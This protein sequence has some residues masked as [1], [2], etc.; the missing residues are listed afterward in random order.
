M[1]DKEKNKKSSF[2]YAFALLPEEKREA[3]NVLY[4]FSR[5]SDEIADNENQ[6]A[7]EKKVRFK[8]WEKAFLNSLRNKS[9]N[10]LLNNLARIIRKYEIPEIYFL[11]LLQGIKTDLE[12]RNIETKKELE[13]YAYSVASTVGLILIHILGFTDESAKDYAIRMGKALQI[14]NIMR[15]VK[16]DATEFTFRKN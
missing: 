11:E 10:E 3:I 8:E 16:T 2:F 5:I 9:E 4:S 7:D 13:N 12:F 1:I 15:D 6:S 14:T